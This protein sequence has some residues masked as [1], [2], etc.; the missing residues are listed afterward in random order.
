MH[1]PNLPLLHVA[2]G[3]VL[4]GTVNAEEVKRKLPPLPEEKRAVL[5]ST[6]ALTAE[7]AY[8]LV[9]FI[10]HRKLQC[11]FKSFISLE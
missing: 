3:P 1:E 5:R 6:Y 4:Q 9:V 11:G 8:I 7:Q 2:V 10:R